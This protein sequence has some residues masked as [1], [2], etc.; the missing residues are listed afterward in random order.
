[1][2]EGDEMTDPKDGNVSTLVGKEEKGSFE[3]GVVRD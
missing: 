1:M 3:T 2:R